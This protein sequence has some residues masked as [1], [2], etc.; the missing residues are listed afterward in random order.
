[1]GRPRL[2]VL[3]GVFCAAAALTAPALAADPI[4]SAAPATATPSLGTLTP[5][6][7]NWAAPQIATVVKALARSPQIAYPRVIC[8]RWDARWR[9]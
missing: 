4:G 3:C 9:G 1:M 6:T 5:A 2:T 8:E 7:V